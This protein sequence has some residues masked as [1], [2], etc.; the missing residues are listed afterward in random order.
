MAISLLESWRVQREAWLAKQ[1][2][3]AGSMDGE[4]ADSPSYTPTQD[5]EDLLDT[6]IEVK[7][8]SF[9]DAQPWRDLV[10][11]NDEGGLFPL[12]NSQLMSSQDS[13]PV[14]TMSE[15]PVPHAPLDITPAKLDDGPAGS[16]KE[17]EGPGNLLKRV[18]DEVA[19]ILSSP[20][21]RVDVIIESSPEAMPTWKRLRRAKHLPVSPSVL[22]M[23]P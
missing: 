18:H 2:L 4:A 14:N 23:V 17:N 1:P 7:E 21:N 15:L 3:P 9:L 11:V 10:D 12:V 6:K 8:E 13:V 19:D 5:D 16:N 20:R 22:S